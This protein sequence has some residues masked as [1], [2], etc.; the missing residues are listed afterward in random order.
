MVESG[1]SVD[2]FI[3]RSQRSSD[4]VGPTQPAD[5]VNVPWLI[6]QTE[7]QAQA[8]LAQYGLKLGTVNR[9]NRQENEKANTVVG[10]NPMRGTVRRGSAVNITIAV[11]PVDVIRDE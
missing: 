2:L 6:G 11:A 3:S 7:Q 5:Q 9:R 1:T 10:Q 4:D 8:T